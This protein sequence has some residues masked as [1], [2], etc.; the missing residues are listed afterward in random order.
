MTLAAIKLFVTPLIMLLAT[1]ASRRWGDAVAGWLVGLPVVSGP[2]S[3]YLTIERGPDFAAL[4]AAGSVSGVVSQAA[5][6]MG[7]AFVASHGVAAAL[8]AA[9]LGYV[10][11]GLVTTALAPPLAALMVAAAAMLF[12]ARAVLPAAAGASALAPAPHWDLPARIVVATV[13][14]FAVT[15]FAGALG[16]RVSGLSASYPIIGGAIAAFAHAVRGPRAGVAAL[17]GMASAL[18][19][20]IA[21]FGV[22][23]YGLGPLAPLP[24]YGLALAMALAT[25]GLTL[26]WLRGDAR[27]AARVGG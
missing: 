15:L 21:F 25:Q 17:R 27:R 13:L 16:P 14:V 5:F 20:F 3:V 18:F 10:G 1:M 8:A 19:G 2:V 12:L 26:L 7:Y 22:I 23:G 24:A 4:S 9:T 6:C 11:F